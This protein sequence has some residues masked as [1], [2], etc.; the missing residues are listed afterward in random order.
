M[1]YNKKNLQ[2]YD[3]IN[4]KSKQHNKQVKNILSGN[5]YN[6][7]N[8]TYYKSLTGYDANKDGIGNSAIIT[9]NF[10]LDIDQKQ[11]ISNNAITD[12]YEYD[13]TNLCHPNNILYDDLK[14]IEKMSKDFEFKY[15]SR[16]VT[17]INKDLNKFLNTELLNEDRHYKNLKKI[18]SILDKNFVNYNTY[19]LLNYYNEWILNS[20]WII[21]SDDVIV[22]KFIKAFKLFMNFYTLTFN[23][24]IYFQQKKVNNSDYI[25][26]KDSIFYEDNANE[27]LSLLDNKTGYSYFNK[28]Y[29]EDKPSTKYNKVYAIPPTNTASLIS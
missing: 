7:I 15:D 14:I 27:M 2:K 6:D 20:N 16:D 23:K 26:S 11:A 28:K 18:I 1:Q 24:K 3:S 22:E 25:V 8:D 10:E 4:S 13:F 19:D 12:F 29:Y 21:T 5:I 9:N 17:H